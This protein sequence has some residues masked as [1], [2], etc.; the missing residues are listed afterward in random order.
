MDIEKNWILIKFL[1]YLNHLNKDV[2][3]K[4]FVAYEET[5]KFKIDKLSLKFRETSVKIE[6][7]VRSLL[8]TLK[9][10]VGCKNLNIESHKNKM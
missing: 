4:S 1:K 3:I 8:K 10:R 9:N 6:Q 2:K 7:E 5:Q